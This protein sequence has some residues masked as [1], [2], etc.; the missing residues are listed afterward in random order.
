VEL[1]DAEEVMADDGL[2]VG[3]VDE[4]DVGLFREKVL[5]RPFVT[6]AKDFPSAFGTG[7]VSPVVGA[8]DDVRR[9]GGEDAADDFA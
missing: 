8:V 3:R 9:V 2:P 6:P 4:E 5:A 7:L 1:G